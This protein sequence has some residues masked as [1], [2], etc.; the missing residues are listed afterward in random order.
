MYDLAALASKRDLIKTGKTVMIYGRAKTGKTKLA[1]SIA[2]S[3]NLDNIYWFDMENGWETLQIGRA[4][5]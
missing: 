1:A 4:H 3:K 5:V 2:K